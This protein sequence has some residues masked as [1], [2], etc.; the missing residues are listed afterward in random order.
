MFRIQRV[1]ALQDYRLKTEFVDGVRGTADVSHRLVKGVFSPWKDYR[2]FQKVFVGSS[3]EPRWNDE[4]D[5]DPDALYLRI[6]GKTP[7]EVFPALKSETLY[8]ER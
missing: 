5:V 7:E 8:A 4:I 3:G 1:E 2:F 6:I